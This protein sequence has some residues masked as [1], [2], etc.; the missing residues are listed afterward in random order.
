MIFI[1]TLIFNI[2]FYAATAML[3]IFGLPLLLLP[4]RVAQN[5][6]VFWAWISSALLKIV[7]ISKRVRGA[8]PKGQAIYALKHQS[9]W[10]TFVL[11]PVFNMPAL[12]LKKELLFYPF[13]GLYCWRVPSMPIDRKAGM[14]SL[15]SI[16]KKAVKIAD[17]GHDILIF[18]QGKR[19]DVNESHPYQIGIFIIYQMTGLPVV[20]VALN[21]GVYWPKSSFCKKPGEIIVEILPSIPPGLKREAFMTQLEQSIEK[22]T[23][24][25]PGMAQE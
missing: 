19:V 23:N 17:E 24:A 1:R 18:P 4:Q 13:F 9:A 15:L 5:Y 20:P 7:G 2:L 3:A 10:E 21:S 8:K 14:A 16:K 12:V 6:V 25:L 11:Y 22:A